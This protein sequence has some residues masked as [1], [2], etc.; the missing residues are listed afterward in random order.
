M[1]TPLARCET[2]RLLLQRWKAMGA[3]P[4]VSISCIP[5]LVG[6]QLVG[7]IGKYSLQLAEVLTVCEAPRVTVQSAWPA[8]SMVQT[9]AASVGVSGTPASLSSARAA[10]AQASRPA[11]ARPAANIGSLM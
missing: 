3:P 2:R 4:F 10:G 11:E 9:P 6:C 8:D 7:L 5:S 1:S